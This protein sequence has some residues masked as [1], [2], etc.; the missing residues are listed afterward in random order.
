[1]TNLQETIKLY[2]FLSGTLYCWLIDIIDSL[3][4][5]IQ[6]YLSMLASFA[7]LLGR[8]VFLFP[9]SIKYATSVWG[10]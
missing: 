1:M 5:K 7:L 3:Q 8:Q 2:V 6:I 10:G 9:D 4:L